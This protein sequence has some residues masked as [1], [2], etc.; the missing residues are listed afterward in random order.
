MSCLRITLLSER[1]INYD[2]CIF[3]GVKLCDINI[4]KNAFSRSIGRLNAFIGEVF[5]IAKVKLRSATA[6]KL[7][8]SE[9]FAYAKIGLFLLASANFT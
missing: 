1:I 4:S 7:F 2:F 8:H 3:Q 5:A 9:V 6:V